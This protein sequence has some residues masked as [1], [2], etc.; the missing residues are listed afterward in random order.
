MLK[1]FGLSVVVSGA[2][3]AKIKIVESPNHMI[4]L[5]RL[6]VQISTSSHYHFGKSTE[7]RLCYQVAV[8]EVDMQQKVFRSQVQA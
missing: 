3:L 8:K 4:T 6:A 1:L 7:R 2:T 5:P